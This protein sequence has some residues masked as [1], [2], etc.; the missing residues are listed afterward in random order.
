ME[1]IT[2]NIATNKTL[3]LIGVYPVLPE[4][5]IYLIEL[6]ISRPTKLVD[7]SMFLQKTGGKNKEDWQAPYDEHYLDER[8][9]RIIG[10]FF[11][12]DDLNCYPTRVVFYMYLETMEVPLTTPYGEVCL[13]DVKE[14]PSR[15][16][17]LKYTPMD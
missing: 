10:D 11:N 16:E 12:H 8:G 1:M 13:T 5:R 14:L 17:M 2:N 3:S 4:E 9:E 15:L 7:L 6:L